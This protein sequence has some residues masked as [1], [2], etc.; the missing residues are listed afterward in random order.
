CC[1][2]SRGVLRHGVRIRAPAAGKRQGDRAFA[3]WSDHGPEAARSFGMLRTLASVTTALVAL[4]SLAQAQP[5]PDGDNPPPAPMTNDW[6]EVSHI[7]GQPV[8]VGEKDD[9]LVKN[10]KHINISTNPI[11]FLLGFY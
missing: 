7:N 11:G 6:S 8:K 9:Y 2:T 4:T 1:R 3:R 10:P 5:G